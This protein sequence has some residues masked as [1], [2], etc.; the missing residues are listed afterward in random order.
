MRFV[1]CT[2]GGSRHAA[3]VDGEDLI[4][5]RGVAELGPATPTSVLAD[6]PL[7]R[8]ATFPRSAARLRPVVPSPGKIICVGLNY[9]AHIE[10]TR[11]EDS[12]YP[13]LF[14]KFATSL[15]GPTDPILVPP[16]S[17]KV[18]WEGEIA[19][20]IGTPAR[21]VSEADALDHVLGYTV[22]NDVS[23]RDF[24]RR[25]HQWLPGKTWDSSNPLGPEL[26]T[27]DEA[28]DFP[29]MEMVV[30]YDDEVVQ[31]TTADLMVFP[32]PELIATISTF[33]TLLPGDVI[34]TG[35]PGGVGDRRD[36]PLYMTPGHRI[37]VEVSGL[38]RIDNE[39]VE[40]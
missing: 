38:G 2:H 33:T 34:L 18:D 7:D 36:P 8:S 25:T 39:L 15:V 27:P 26:V 35:T 14:T 22:A 5:L 31:R 32:V 16:E 11:R 37:S 4:P 23:M 12:A 1:S 29:D 19:V 17:E 20:V 6:P 3:L 13:V 30:R 40:G 9:R 28:P 21:R 10:E 24:Q